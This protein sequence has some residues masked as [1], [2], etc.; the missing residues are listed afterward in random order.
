MNKL[1]IT[2]IGVVLVIT[3]TS[4]QSAMIP[5]DGDS[6][7]E[8]T[9]A[10][11]ASND[12]WSVSDGLTLIVSDDHQVGEKSVGASLNAG[13]TWNWKGI[14][15]TKS[16]SIAQ[17]LAFVFK[18]KAN[19]A[20]KV[21]WISIEMSP[22]PEEQANGITKKKIY[23]QWTTSNSWSEFNKS[24]DDS[25][26]TWEWQTLGWKWNGANNPDVDNDGEDE[27]SKTLTSLE[28]IGWYANGTASG[29]NQLLLDGIHFTAIPEPTTL[30]LVSLGFLGL[31]SIRKK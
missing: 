12:G 1:M 13:E 8:Y 15:L 6:W 19:I 3:F 23:R 7:S 11:D 31:G 22:T 5:A 4:V 28:K 30:G 2:V 26:W 10:S 14:F 20:G 21:F 9:T 16:D 17:A 25:G 24:L 18:Y 29:M 27:G